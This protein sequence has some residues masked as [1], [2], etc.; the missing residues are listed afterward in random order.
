MI[1]YDLIC[2]Q[3]H[4]FEAWF[5]DSHTFDRLK[6]SKSLTCEV[7]GSSHVSKAIM[8]P[9]LSAMVG[10][11]KRD[12]T[13]HVQKPAQGEVV[14]DTAAPIK[15]ADPAITGPAAKLSAEQ[16]A[17]IRAM[18]GKVNTYVENNFENVGDKFADEARAIHGGKTEERGIYGDATVKEV[19]ELAEEGIDVV[20]LPR[21]NRKDTQ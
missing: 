15:V 7:C 11:E 10:A 19:H 2:D 6:A 17:E 1:L 12:K 16:H 3:G 13:R 8:A 21:L 4:E 14:K 9:Q 5:K 18:L 20:R